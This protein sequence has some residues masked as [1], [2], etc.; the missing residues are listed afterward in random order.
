MRPVQKKALNAV[1]TCQKTKSG[2]CILTY[3]N[4]PLKL[5]QPSRRF[6]KTLRMRNAWRYLAVFI[7][8]KSVCHNPKNTRSTVI[9]A[10][11]KYNRPRN[12]ERRSQIHAQSLFAIVRTSQMIKPNTDAKLIIQKS[13]TLLT[14]TSY[15]RIGVESR[16]SFLSPPAPY[17]Y[18]R[19]SRT[20]GS[21]S[22]TCAL[23]DR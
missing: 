6:K 16:K 13:L 15:R 3:L 11:R 17:V 5:P 22:H 14:K 18:F 7:A 20:S 1:T 23:S 19:E 2:S 12:I 10:V 8:L 9:E 4:H 21:E